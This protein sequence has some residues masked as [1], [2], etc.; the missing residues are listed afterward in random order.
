M[1]NAIILAAGAPH[2]GNAPTIFFKQNKYFNNFDILKIALKDYTKKV[3]LVAGYNFKKI[4]NNKKI[5]V[6]IIYNSKWKV[7]KVFQV[8]C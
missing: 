1:K 5:N 7:R 2:S 3:S 4:K 6:K 8:C